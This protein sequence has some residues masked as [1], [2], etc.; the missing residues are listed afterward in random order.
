MLAL[1][2]FGLVSLGRIF[3]A[4]AL[5]EIT[6]NGIM[7]MGGAPQVLFHVVNP[8][9]TVAYS[10]SLAE[11]DERDGIKVIAI[12]QANGA[13]TFDN[14]G[15]VQQIG[16]QKASSPVYVPSQP[17]AT[18]STANFAPGVPPAPVTTPE[19]PSDELVTLSS[20]S[21]R[22]EEPPAVVVIGSR[23]TGGSYQHFNGL[24][25]N[26]PAG[27]SSNAGPSLPHHAGLQK[28]P[29]STVPPTPSAPT[30]PGAPSQ[31]GNPTW[32][33][34]NP[35]QGIGVGAVNSAPGLPPANGVGGLPPGFTTNPG[36]RPPTP[37]NSSSAGVGKQQSPSSPPGK[38]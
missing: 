25:P 24:K 21:V 12:D 29:Q 9:S 18:P 35:G 14:H 22:N 2:F 28:P 38:Q 15:T 17:Q 16:L 1:T 37:G 6:P 20:T 10:Y 34:N 33:P 5:P 11:G 8:G 31:P 36:N 30:S 7:A 23:S 13:V 27:D 26:N 19:P 4:D 3:A 32:S